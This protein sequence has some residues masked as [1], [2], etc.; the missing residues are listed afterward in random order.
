MLRMTD[1][2]IETVGCFDTH[3]TLSISEGSRLVD[4]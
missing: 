2:M 4:S 1:E 3:V